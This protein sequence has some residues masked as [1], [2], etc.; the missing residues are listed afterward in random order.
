MNRHSVLLVCLL[1]ATLL[2]GCEPA[3]TPQGLLAEAKEYRSKGDFKSALIQAKNAVQLSP[4]LAE[5]HY[6]KGALYLDLGE[7]TLAEE[8]LRQALALKM[9]PQEV[10]PVLARALLK[11]GKYQDVL[12]ETVPERFPADWHSA[13]VASLRGGAYLGLK[14]IPDAK[15]AYEKALQYEADFPDALVGLAKI[16]A[17]DRRPQEGMQ[18]VERALAKSPTNFDALLLK[19]DL[20]RVLGNP[21]AALSAYEEAVRQ[22]PD[23]LNARITLAS[24]QIS[25]DKNDDA[26]ANLAEVLKEA[27]QSPTANYMQALIEFRKKNFVA[28]QNR[29]A[30]V[31][32]VQPAHVPVRHA[33]RGGRVCLRRISAGRAAPEMA[34]RSLP[35]QPVRAQAARCDLQQ[36]RKG[37]AGDRH[38]PAGA[39]AGAAGFEFV[40]SRR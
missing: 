23:D 37:P 19:G 14:R 40:R 11:Q 35:E 29:A 27:P 17:A 13:D 22:K 30:E 18:L 24:I 25:L 28:A 15:A 12:D 26:T 4:E 34:A 10:I 6:L 33:C 20:Q 32:K 5:A 9:A 39:E 38:A 3:T 1:A 21:P 7:A 2:V 36:E 8:G 31:L 16:T